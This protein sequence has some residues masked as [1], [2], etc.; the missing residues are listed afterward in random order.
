MKL[1]LIAALSTN[2][3]L[4]AKGG[5]FLDDLADDLLA[6]VIQSLTNTTADDAT[7]RQEFNDAVHNLY[8]SPFGV[9]MHNALF[10]C[11]PRQLQLARCGDPQAHRGCN[12]ANLLARKWSGTGVC[13]VARRY[14][15]SAAQVSCKLVITRDIV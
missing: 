5:D 11:G 4:A 8:V 14:F 15:E 3:T 9:Q 6:V 10:S 2:P 7:A 12:A 13:A 1:K